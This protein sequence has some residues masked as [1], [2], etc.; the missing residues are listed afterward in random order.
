MRKEKRWYKNRERQRQES[1]E[2]IYLAPK[3]NFS[4]GVL[5]TRKALESNSPKIS[6]QICNQSNKLTYNLSLCLFMP[7]IGTIFLSSVIQVQN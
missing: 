6:F 3:K 4:E 5:Q 7:S 2:K 1:L